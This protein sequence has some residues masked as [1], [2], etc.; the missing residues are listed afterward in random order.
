MDIHEYQAK[1]ILSTFGISVPKGKVA[2]TLSEAVQQAALLKNGHSSCWVIK[3]QIHSGGRGKSGGIQFAHNLEDVATHAQNLLG[4]RLI[5][6]QTGSEAKKVN[7]LYIEE[8]IPIQK[9]FYVSFFLNRSLARIS[10]LFSL[11]GGTNVEKYNENLFP[12]FNCI[13]LD[14]FLGLT[15]LDIHKLLI[16]FRFEKKLLEKLEKLLQQLYNVYTSLD[17]I[18]LEINPLALTES[19]D[20][21]CVDAKM[22]FDDNAL[23][24]QSNIRALRDFH[25]Q[26]KFEIEATQY[27]L[28][29]I[30]LKGN[31][32]CLANGAGL[33]MATLDL[34]HS[35]GGNAANFLDMGG[36][37]TEEKILKAFQIILSD[38]SVKGILVNIFGGILPCKNVA[39][40]L[41][42]ALKDQKKCLPIV[43]RF[44]GNT[45]KEAHQIIRTSQFPIHMTTDLEE[46]SQRIIDAVRI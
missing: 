7:I 12:D 25:E 3:A 17:A 44:I 21:V 9:E 43:V 10:V 14:P 6:S 45:E 29:Y 8:S 37:A 15:S 16:P 39:K 35:K 23:F 27:G 46:A 1:K 42:Q 40:A 36:R 18:L 2:Y 11:K 28:H 33:A 26:D 32:G 22:S 5:T 31:I 34:L 38:S 19:E 13:S 20:L 24:R 30:K 41:V 4:K